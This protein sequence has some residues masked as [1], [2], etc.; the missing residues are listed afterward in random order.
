MVFQDIG[1]YIS[2]K[3]KIKYILKF[4]IGIKVNI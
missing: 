4:I 3:L 1:V 2:Q